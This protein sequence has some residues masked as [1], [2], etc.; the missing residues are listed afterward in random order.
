MGNPSSITK[1]FLEPM[2][3][4]GDSV[5]CSGC[6][7][8]RDAPWRGTG[9]SPAI[10]SGFASCLPS[11]QQPVEAL[12]LAAC[13][14]DRVVAMQLEEQERRIRAVAKEFRDIREDLPKAKK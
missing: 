5:W 12:A 8:A 4:Q 6:C 10:D 11:K 9:S 1:E 13:A 2:P 14:A 7:D 3:R